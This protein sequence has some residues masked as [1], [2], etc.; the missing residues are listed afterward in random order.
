MKTKRHNTLLLMILMFGAL[1]LGNYGSS[2]SGEL[3]HY[4]PGVA[5]IRDF[6]VPAPGFYYAQY[7]VFYNTDSYRDRN[8][9][10]VSS[11]TIGD[12]TLTVEADVNVFALVPTFIWVSEEKLL[13]ANYGLFISPTLTNTSLQAS[14]STETRFGRSIDDSQFGLGDLYMRPLW[15]G[16]N[17][18]NYALSAGYGFYLP[19]GKYDD[20]ADDNTGLGFWTHEFQ[21]SGTWFP[22]EHQGTAVMLAGT[23]EIHH[24]KEGADITPGDRFS[25][26]WG[27][28]QYL[29]LTKDQNLL[30]ELGFIGYNQWQVAEDSGSDVHDV[31]KVK[32]QLHGVGTQ[33]GLAYVPWNASLTFRYMNEYNAEARFEG[34]LITVTFAKGF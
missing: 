6:I 22:W 25:M 9:N 32:D 13:G 11:I 24:N 4:V 14:L 7:H 1:L 12:Q 29:P 27:F 15:L 5:S 19:V 33:L 2:Q 21:A 30:A 17:S 34:D 3:G 20:G 10:S 16:W 8:G 18:T 23:Y 28:S 26:D 31:L